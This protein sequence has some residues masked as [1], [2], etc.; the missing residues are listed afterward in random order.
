MKSD[1]E[2]QGYIYSQALEYQSHYPGL[3]FGQAVFNTVYELWPV[4]AKRYRA[5]ELD[6]Y[7]HDN[8]VNRFIQQCVQ[9]RHNNCPAYRLAIDVDQLQ[10]ACR[11]LSQLGQVMHGQSDEP[12]DD[13]AILVEELQELSEAHH[14]R[15]A[16]LSQLLSEWSG[17]KTDLGI[18]SLVERIQ[19]PEP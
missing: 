18:D 9:D 5:T 10:L 13:Q 7:Y 16:R 6:P 14:Q 8:R 17:R 11:L 12:E 2:W 3:R 15:F 1:A 4:V 19:S